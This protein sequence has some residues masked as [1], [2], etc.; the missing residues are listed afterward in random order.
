[1]NKVQL[2]IIPVL[3]TPSGSCLTTKNWQETGVT[4]VSYEL[5]AL[6]LKPGLDYLK[7]LSS[8]ANYY[9][10][11]GEWVLNASTLKANS[12]GIFVLRSPFDG[13]RV[14]CTREDI[15]T[16]IMQLEPQY[17]ILPKGFHVVS[18]NCYQEMS[19]NTQLFI[20]VSEVANYPYTLIQGLYYAG[21]PLDE[22]LADIRDHK[23]DYPHALHYVLA[24]IFSMR[25]IADLGVNF[26]E[27]DDLAKEACVGRVIA[28]EGIID[29]THKDYAM[30]FEVVDAKCTCPTC[31]QQFTR[32]Y[33]HHLLEH[34]PLLCQ[35]MLIQHN[36]AFARSRIIC[37]AG[38]AAA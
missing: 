9:P 22:V 11:G 30:Q 33:L 8:M 25:R 14:T 17:A 13:A 37:S 16:L 28:S 31:A 1:M 38:E 35:R 4:R 7:T 34:T 2:D 5:S 10:W 23:R 36:V 20:P 29:L 24:D 21:G 3:T 12:E 19:Q 26:I 15:V 32:A 27:S 6:L 18:E